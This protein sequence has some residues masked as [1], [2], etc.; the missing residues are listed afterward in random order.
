MKNVYLLILVLLLSSCSSIPIST[1]LKFRSFNEQ[2][3]VA[4][5]GSE[6]RSKIIVSQPFTLDLEKIKLSLTLDND[7]GVRNFTYP[8]DLDMQKTIAAQDG[9]F[10][11]TPAKT[12]YTFKLSELAVKNFKETQNLI[13]DQFKGETSFSIAA[14]FNE[15]PTEGQLVTLSILLQLDE[16]DGYFTLIDNADID[17]GNE[18]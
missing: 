14:G 11:S 9:F 12:E 7:K 17:V 15:E 8:L 13:S 6:I 18:D 2:S 16:E 4:L 1:M 10:T 5:N 3:F